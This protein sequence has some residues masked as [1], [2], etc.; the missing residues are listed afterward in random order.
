MKNEYLKLIDND[1]FEIDNSWENKILIIYREVS[2]YLYIDELKKL[3]KNNKSETHTLYN[4]KLKIG[5]NEIKYLFNMWEENWDEK[6][7][8]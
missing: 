3:L 8:Y 6:I 1:E 5:P 7:I 4:K 2:F